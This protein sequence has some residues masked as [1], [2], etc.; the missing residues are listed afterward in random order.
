MGLMS[1][2]AQ[3]AYDTQVNAQNSQAN[4]AYNAQMAAIQ[5]SQDRANRNMRAHPY[6]FAGGG[7]IAFGNGGDVPRFLSG[8]GDGLS[9]SIDATIDNNQPA[10]LADGEFVVSSDVVSGLGGGSS[11]AGAKKLYAMMDRVRKQA[12]GT[13]KQI[14]PVST[15]ALPA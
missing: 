3:R 14:R 12:H 6:Q 4:N 11:K 9:D 8:G 10:K 15:K 13:K 7:A 2:D 1:S 5:D